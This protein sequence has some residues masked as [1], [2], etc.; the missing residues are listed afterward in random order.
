MI[1]KKRQGF[2]VMVMFVISMAVSMIVRAQVRNWLPANTT[3]AINGTFETT[4]Q[5]DR[6]ACS[7]D[8]RYQCSYQ[9]GAVGDEYREINDF[10]MYEGDNIMYKMDRLPGSDFM[11]SNS[12]RLAVFDMKQHYN[13]RLRMIFYDRTGSESGTMEFSSATQFGFSPSGEVFSLALSGMLTLIDLNNNSRTTLGHAF[14]Y[15]LSDDASLAALATYHGL[16]RLCEDGQPVR[17]VCTGMEYIRKVAVSGRDRLAAVADA[18]NL[19]I[20]TVDGG[21]EVFHARLGQDYSYRDL[22]FTEGAVLAGVHEKKK[23]LSTGFLYVYNLSGQLITREEFS[24]KEFRTFEPESCR[25]K[26]STGYDPIPWP[27][28]PFNEVHTVWNHYEQH[29]GDGSSTWSYLHQGLDIIVPVAE[30]IYAVEGGY[31]KCV[32][33][34]GGEYYW[35]LAVSPVQSP[36]YSDG[37]LYAHLIQSTIQVAPGDTVEQYDYLGDIIDW[38]TDWGH[39]H[40]VQIR[41]TGTVWQYEDN[42]WGIN[43]NPLL[44]ITPNIDPVAPQ[45]ENVFTNAK[46]AFCLN[47]TS[48][49][50]N[51]NNLHGSIDIIV[52]ISDYHADS[53]WEQP[54]YMTFYEVKKLPGNITVFPKTLGQILNH[55]YPFYET[56][57]YEAYAP[58]MYKM[59]YQFPSPPWSYEDR[60]YYQVLTNNNGDSL[61]ELPEKNLA[62]KTTDYID[63]NY[64]IVVEAWD[65][66]GNFDVDSMDVVFNNG[67]TSEEEVR[68]G[69]SIARIYPN[70]SSGLIFIEP[71]DNRT[72]SCIYKLTLLDRDCRK[73]MEATGDSRSGKDQPWTLDVSGIPGGVYFLVIGTAERSEVRKIAVL[74]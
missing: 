51:A 48:T 28:V 62:F 33:T 1:M 53:P 13:Q 49:Y 73:V 35:R 66:A 72:G 63:G 58:L 4:R 16:L 55:T 41:D 68:T 56:G 32:L 31:V 5:A 17:E 59:D 39:T 25:E 67:I 2:I 19:S 61:A 38:F 24:S 44:A 43:F 54:A 34:I 22:L 10:T 18:K 57:H 9:V 70:P 14:S 46:F 50:L 52:K 8:G 42:E 69:N 64:R 47:E 60:D 7:P 74:D 11:L 26:S 27:F 20:F 45:I 65:E 37:W 15:G 29:M 21:Q 30:P 12:G 3:V 23:G 71:M 40:F 6:K 36:G